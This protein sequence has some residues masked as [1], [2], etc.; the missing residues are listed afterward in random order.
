M[1]LKHLLIIAFSLISTACASVSTQKNIETS[2]ANTSESV[3][4][5]FKD[6][7]SKLTYV[8]YK[9]EHVLDEQARLDVINACRLDKNGIDEDDFAKFVKFD[10]ASARKCFNLLKDY[11]IAEFLLH[12]SLE[13]DAYRDFQKSVSNYEQYY[14]NN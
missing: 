1:N 5:N 2:V 14:F 13:K 9:N 7:M 4:F 3:M 6:P 8:I 11:Y 10:K 12:A